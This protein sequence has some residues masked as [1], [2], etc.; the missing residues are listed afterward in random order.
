MYIVNPNTPGPKVIYGESNEAKPTD[1]HEY[2]KFVEH[3]TGD[4][5]Y[6]KNGSWLI[7]GGEE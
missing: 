6:F 5:Y 4:V 2:S 1:V 7:F 3:D